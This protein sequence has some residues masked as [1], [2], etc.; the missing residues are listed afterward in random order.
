M[1]EKTA[2]ASHQETVSWPVALGLGSLALVWPLAELTGLSD[3][4]GQP[5][6]AFALFGLVALAWIGTVGFCRVPRPVLTL[7][8]A[9]AV[10]GGILVAL[11]VAFG[12]HPDL[13]I[14]AVG[15]AFFEI[16][17]SALLGGIAGL[18]ARALQKA[19]GRR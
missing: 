12:T 5:T 8:V 7:T 15:V 2:R 11:S 16:V 9:G 18:I 10:Y 19:L 14:L 6:M 13:G 4:I 1:T 3:A 17:R